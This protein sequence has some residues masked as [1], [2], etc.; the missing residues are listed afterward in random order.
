MSSNR[1]NGTSLVRSAPRESS[2]LSDHI[3]RIAD[4]DS[5]LGAALADIAVK[6]Q[7]LVKLVQQRNESAS[8]C[9][10][11]LLLS[12]KEASESLG[13]SDRT[14][15][16]NTVPRGSIPSVKIGGRVLY[17][18]NDL[19]TFIERQKRSEANSLLPSTFAT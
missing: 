2:S 12:A 3:A 5:A 18:L 6:Q 7:E 1:A 4:F 13:V 11:K 8:I 15:W 19:R 17:D 9:E 10:G 16:S 14:L